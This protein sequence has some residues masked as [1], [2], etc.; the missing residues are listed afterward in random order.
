MWEKI[1]A[2]NPG[3][4][5]EPDMH[6]TR[7]NTSARQTA[8]R[9]NRPAREYPAIRSDKNRVKTCDAAAKISF[10]LAERRRMSYDGHRK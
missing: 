4:Y 5:R 8:H 9:A 7:E 10:C 1:Y 6:P 2:L 3:D